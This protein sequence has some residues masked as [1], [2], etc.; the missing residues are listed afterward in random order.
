MARQEFASDYIDVATRIAEFR[1]LYPTGSLQQ[2]A[3]DFKEFA[4]TSWVIYTAAAYRTPDD[5][6]PG[7]GTA[8]EPVPGLSPFTKWSELQNAETAAWGR[9]IVATLAADAKKGIASAEEVRNSRERQAPK[10]PAE[11]ARDELRALC[12]EKGLDLLQVAQDYAEGHDGKPLKD[13]TENDV[14]R[15]IALVRSGIPTEDLVMSPAQKAEHKAL[16]REVRGEAP[17]GRRS[18]DDGPEGQRLASVPADDPWYV[19]G[20]GA[21]DTD[22]P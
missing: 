2:A 7:H 18:K 3:L 15:F 12:Q 11:I 21:P 20:L 10:S 14:R 16:V 5:E 8:W 9:A 4:G 1:A 6:R 13:A 19:D 22:A 17:S